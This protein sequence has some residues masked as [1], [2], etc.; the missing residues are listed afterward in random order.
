MS[1]MAASRTFKIN[2]LG[3]VMLGRLID[4]LFPTHVNSAEESRIVDSFKN[5]HAQLAN[6]GPETPWGNVLPLIRSGDLNIIN[7]ETSVTTHDIK[8]PDK[9]FNYR[10]HPDNIEA[11]RVADIDVV[12]LANNHTLDFC[13]AGFVETLKTIRKAPTQNLSPISF[14]GAG[15]TAEEAQRHTGCFLPRHIP[16]LLPSHPQYVGQRLVDIYSFSDHPQDWAFVPRFNFIDYTEDTRQRVKKRLLGKDPTLPDVRIVSIHWGPNYCRSPS[17]EIKALAH[18][19][20]EE[21]DVDIIHG[22]SS[23]H[24]QGV[25]IYKGKLILYGCGDFVDDYAVNAEWRNDLSALWRVT[26]QE[27]GEKLVLRRLEVFPNRIRNFQA[28][29]LDRKDAD[30]KWLTKRFRELCAE[31]GTSLEEEL[32]DD[33][34]IV[35]QIC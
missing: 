17:D 14:V 10:M 1:M 4:Q 35:V 18:F 20:I 33:G 9:I 24:I 6:H 8:W 22:H 7:L 2:L 28:G 29:L 16:F 19:F 27:E 26:V 5:Q 12:S 34:Q 25:E 31:M 32:G 13:E 21:C 23:H 11:L 15:A 30:H 3:D